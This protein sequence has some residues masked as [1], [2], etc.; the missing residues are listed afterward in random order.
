MS[1]V[2]SLPAAVEALEDKARTHKQ[3]D[4]IDFHAS[5]AQHNISR[6]NE[7]L[8][9]LVERLRDLRYY[10]RVL[11]RAFDGSATSVASTVQVAEQVADVTQDDLLSNVRGGEMME[12]DVDLDDESPSQSQPE[13]K[14]TPEVEKQIKRIQ[15]AKEQAKSAAE[16]VRAQLEGKQESWLT[17]VEA[18]EELQ[19]IIGGGNSGF[20]KTLNHMHNLLTREL[21]DPSG[22]ASTFVSKWDSATDDWERHQSLQSLDDFQQKHDLAD[23]TIDDVRTLSQSR[24]LTLAD[25]SIESLREMKGVDELESA[26]NLSL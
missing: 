3:A 12:T 1:D 20:A 15:S 14:L 17:R 18:A 22:S 6:V 2:Q 24:E 13:V 26:V 7:E 5:V 8:D 19:R 10:K 9:E 4:N 21:L 11:E 25:V 16:T 23:S